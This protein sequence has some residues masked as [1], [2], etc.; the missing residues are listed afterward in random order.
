MNDKQR[1]DM[2]KMV[3]NANFSNKAERKAAKKAFKDCIKQSNK[4]IE[5][6]LA[7]EPDDFR[8][9]YDNTRGKRSRF[10]AHYVPFEMEFGASKQHYK[11]KRCTRSKQY[12]WEGIN[13]TM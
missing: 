7:Y 5:H 6:G 1:K 2:A 12:K 8:E 11:G 13:A 4:H 9:R 10:G 3:K